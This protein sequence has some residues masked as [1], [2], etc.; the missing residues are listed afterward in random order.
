MHENLKYSINFD[1]NI[2]PI[3]DES[4][5][6]SKEPLEDSLKRQVADW[7]PIYSGTSYGTRF[8]IYAKFIGQKVNSSFELSTIQFYLQNY[9]GG[10]SI[11]LN[12]YYDLRIPAPSANDPDLMDPKYPN[13][14]KIV[15]DIGLQGL[16]NKNLKMDYKPQAVTINKGDI[17]KVNSIFT[18][19]ESSIS[20]IYDEAGLA[21]SKFVDEL[22]MERNGDE[23]FITSEGEKKLRALQSKYQLVNPTEL[24][25]AGIDVSIPQNFISPVESRGRVFPC[26]PIT[27]ICFVP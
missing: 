15:I 9:E 6:N 16:N 26:Q 8:F 13:R 14:K 7:Q 4:L 21:K 25:D 23:I 1:Q 22:F 11:G 5:L 20:S 10:V 17:I 18:P 24:L 19:I 2:I 27:S 12:G 3:K